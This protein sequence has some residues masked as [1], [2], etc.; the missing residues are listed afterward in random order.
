MRLSRRQGRQDAHQPKERRARS[1]NNTLV[2]VVHRRRGNRITGIPQ[3]REGDGSNGD[4][5]RGVCFDRVGGNG[6]DYA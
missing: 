2:L 1:S 4:G 6:G 5:V 3:N